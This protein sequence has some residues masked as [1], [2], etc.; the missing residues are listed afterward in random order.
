M[1]FDAW[2]QMNAQ[3]MFDIQSLQARWTESHRQSTTFFLDVYE[4]TVGRLADAHV[5]TA[6]GLDNPVVLTIAEAQATISR[7]VAGVCVSTARKL[8]DD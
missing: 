1:A 4:Q 5:K 3:E 2:P 8:L 6:R 7:D